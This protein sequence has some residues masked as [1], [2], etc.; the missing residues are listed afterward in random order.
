VLIGTD[1]FTTGY[2]KAKQAHE[3]SWLSG[4]I[5]ARV[6]RAS[7]FHE[8]VSQM[9]AWGRDNGVSYLQRTRT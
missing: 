4:P 9:L 2:G 7:Q 3:E 8:F 5:P 1:R 6:L